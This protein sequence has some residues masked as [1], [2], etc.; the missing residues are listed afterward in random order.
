MSP[1]IC[2]II[3]LGTIAYRQAWD[4]QVQLTQAVHDGRQPNTLLL[5]EHPH[6]YTK[7][8]LSKDEHLLLTP[9]QLAERGIDLVETDRGGEAAAAERTVRR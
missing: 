7:G 5:L 9:A 4:L 6:V 3:D 1:P 8:R 2:Q